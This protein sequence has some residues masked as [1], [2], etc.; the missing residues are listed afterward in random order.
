MDEQLFFTY[1][2]AT[3]GDRLHMAS[4]PQSIIEL[5]ETFGLRCGADASPT[6]SGKKY[7]QFSLNNLSEKEKMELLTSI[8]PVKQLYG[9][10]L[11][12]NDPKMADHKFMKLVQN[13]T[14]KIRYCYGCGGSSEITLKE[15]IELNNQIE[16]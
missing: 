8:N 13:S 4:A 12:K 7:Q 2:E 10:L 9:Y 15:I 1:I 6:S 11:L 14:F 5:R 3:Y 16:K